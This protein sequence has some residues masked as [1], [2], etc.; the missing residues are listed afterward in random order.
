MNKDNVAFILITY[1][2]N[3][4][5]YNN[6]DIIIKSTLMIASTMILIL[7]SITHGLVPLII[8]CIG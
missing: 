7:Y 6:I 5:W 8:E 2:A 4:I 1:Y 3:V